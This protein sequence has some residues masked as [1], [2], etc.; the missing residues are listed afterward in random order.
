MTWDLVLM[1]IFN[2]NDLTDSEKEIMFNLY[3]KLKDLNFPSIMSQIENRF[4][5]RI[6]LDKTI[7]KILGFSNREINEW[8][9]KIYN[10]IV[11][12]LKAMKSL[13]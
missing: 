13:K 1:K 3:E 11:D 2:F 4:N 9:P 12:E 10:T 5:A 6:E 8:L 7:L